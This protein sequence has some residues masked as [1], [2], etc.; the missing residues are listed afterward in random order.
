MN[1]DHKP[2]VKDFIKSEEMSISDIVFNKDRQFIIPYNQR[3]WSWSKSQIERLWGD[4]VLTAKQYHKV[5]A[6]NA[7]SELG[8]IDNADPHFFGAFLLLAKNDPYKWELVDGQQRITALMMI[9]AVLREISHYV[10][11]Q[12]VD[13][14]LKRKANTWSAGITSSWLLCNDDPDNEESKLLLDHLHMRIYEIYILYP[15]T[16]E[17]REEEYEKLDL[18]EKKYPNQKNIKQRF[19]ELRES[20]ISHTESLDLEGKFNF[21]KAIKST[22]QYA[23]IGIKVEVLNEEYSFHVFDCLNSTGLPLSDIDNVKNELFKLSDRSHHE[24]IKKKWD[25]LANLCPDGDI[26]QFLRL[27]HIAIIDKCPKNKLF[28]TIRDEELNKSN[29]LDLLDEW[30]ADAKNVNKIANKDTKLF[31][32][33]ARKELNEILDILNISYSYILLIKAGREY[34]AKDVKEFE[35]FITLTR[36]FCFRMLT[37]GEKETTIL[38]ESLGKAARCLDSGKLKDVVDLLTNYNND[39]EF[40]S[41]FSNRVIKDTKTQYMILGNIENYMRGNRGPVAGPHGQYKNN[42][43]HIMPKTLSTAAG[44][45]KEWSWA[46]SH[47]EEKKVYT[48]RLGNLL[49][50]EPDINKHLSN[51][52]FTAKQQG[53]Y[54][55]KYSKVRGPDSKKV[56]RKSYKNSDYKMVK[57]I[58]DTS[59]YPEWSFKAIENRQKELAER[60]A[61]VWKLNIK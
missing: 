29:I 20:I 13:K 41:D 54:P 61:K 11:E 49:I 23:F 50:I 51:F 57:E 16:Q 15:I 27:R 33:D 14:S 26:A 43:E 59:K 18:D 44:R 1:P 28:E 45:E 6:P 2:R 34:L 5:D 47:P 25:E 56:D 10:S 39:V 46:R 7:W 58:C 42:I 21:C 17:E 40:K 38:E 24:R 37:I 36:N 4:V 9:G 53:H 22:I 3:P 35:K 48:N 30:L 12:A 8:L 55:Q 32:E 52:D 19:D 60:A 31:S